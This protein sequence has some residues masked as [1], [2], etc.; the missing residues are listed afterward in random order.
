MKKK[1]MPTRTCIFIDHEE[2]PTYLLYF[3]L[4]SCSGIYIVGS[5]TESNKTKCN[6]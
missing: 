2:G 3:L 5:I 6:R 1:Q 4:D